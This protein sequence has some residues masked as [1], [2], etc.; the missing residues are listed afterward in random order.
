MNTQ[1]REGSGT[2]TPSLLS[3]RTIALGA[4]WSV[5]VILAA[6]A[7][8]AAAASN[9]P[10]VHADGTL[11]HTTGQDY[12][13]TMIYTLTAPK[14]STATIGVTDIRAASKSGDTVTFTP[15]PGAQSLSVGANPLPA[16]S[17]TRSDGSNSAKTVTLIYTCIIVVNGISTTTTQS[18]IVPI[19]Y[20]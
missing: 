5:P 12:L 9:P 18:V 19:S 20:P 10:A 13:L 4:V 6:T 16:V 1:E 8:P 11:V 15:L 14:G 3:R 2:G 7:A 17:V